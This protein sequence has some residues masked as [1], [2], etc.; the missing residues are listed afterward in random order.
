MNWHS[1]GG[2]SG[3]IRM[4][5]RNHG[6]SKRRAEKA[7]NA[8]FDCMI[9]AVERGEEV[10]IPVGRIRAVS[11]TVGHQRTV[12]QKFRN[13]HSGAIFRTR[14]QHPKRIIRFS[15]DPRLVRGDRVESSPTLATPELNSKQEEL[16][17]AFLQL[18]GRQITVPDLE[19]LLD[20]AVDPN[21]PVAPEARRDYLDRLLAR[22]RQIL[23]DERRCTD[24]HSLRD[25]V[26]QMYWIRG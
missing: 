20:A 5:M 2:K 13:I 1:T 12:I 6:L 17:Q 18:I 23:R 16:E 10:E 3:L 26:R 19:L 4:L 15:P 8:V 11:A 24:V 25:L 21:K 22:L 9:R 14:A 7:V